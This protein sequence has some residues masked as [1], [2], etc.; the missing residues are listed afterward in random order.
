MVV[1]EEDH[2]GPRR[3][4]PENF[5]GRSGAG[6]V[7]VDER[8]VYEQGKRLAVGA[9]L[10]EGSQAKGQVELKEWKGVITE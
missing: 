10:L 2:L 5:Q 6:V 4:I 1:S 3:Q 7:E 9:E 8:I